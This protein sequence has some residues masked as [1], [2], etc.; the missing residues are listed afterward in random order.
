MPKEKILSNYI[1]SQET[2]IKEW[3]ENP[4]STWEKSHFFNLKSVNKSI[5]EYINFL[6]EP[7]LGNPFQ[8]TAV[9]LN[10]NPGPVIDC[11]QERKFGYFFTKNKA[12]ENYQNF[13][14]NNKYMTDKKG[15]WG[16]KRSFIARLSDIPFEETSF[17]A[18]EICPWHSNS[19]RLDQK[20]LQKSLDY[21]QNE[22]LTIAESAAM[23]SYFKTIFT[24]GK[25]F[26]DVFNMLG[27]E[28]LKEISERDEIANWPKNTNGQKTIRTLSKW[29]SKTNGVYF[30]TFSPGSNKISSKEF[31]KIILEELNICK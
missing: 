30:N 5:S 20:D 17:F 12:A 29:R 8:S 21:I 16:M 31:D 1:E 9:F 28:L 2:F 11:L 24:V 19:F 25:N 18:L 14:L 10:Y 27:F 23:N 22:V 15:F 13:A 4:K 3:Y 26:Y 6:P 7:Y